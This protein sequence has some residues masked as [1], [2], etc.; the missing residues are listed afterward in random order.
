MG[1]VLSI[2]IDPTLPSSDQSPIVSEILV[3][4]NGVRER[5]YQLRVAHPSARSLRAWTTFLRE[6]TGL[7]VAP[8]MVHR[9]EL[10]VPEA[11]GTA[12]PLR[13]VYAVAR[14]TG[15]DPL[16]ILGWAGRRGA[17]PDVQHVPPRGKGRP[18]ARM[19]AQ[20]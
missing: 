5:L 19:K 15:T 11:S 13:Y 7:I 10:V 12:I 9:Y 3:W 6:E 2:R 17:V 18:A 4:E 20:R 8:T 1:G 14:A 16:W